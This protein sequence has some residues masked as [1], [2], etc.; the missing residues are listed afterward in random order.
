MN[1]QVAR[2]NGVDCMYRLSSRLYYSFLL[3]AALNICRRFSN[4]CYIAFA[5]LSPSRSRGR[6][7][8]RQDFELAIQRMPIILGV[9]IHFPVS[10]YSYCWSAPCTVL[11]LS[12]LDVSID[13]PTASMTLSIPPYT[14]YRARLEEIS[15]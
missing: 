13:A 1:R 12:C 14:R 3:C 4:Y 5:D 10:S 8:V 15:V 11:R 6:C 7:M 2:F 9:Y